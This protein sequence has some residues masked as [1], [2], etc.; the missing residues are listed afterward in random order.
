MVHCVPEIEASVCQSG[1]LFFQQDQFTSGS[2]Q[3]SWLPGSGSLNVGSQVEAGGDVPDPHGVVPVDVPP[4][5]LDPG[6]LQSPEGPR[7]LHHGA[8]LVDDDA[9]GGF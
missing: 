8:A 9:D 5:P 3:I 6:Q 4:R 2:R 7:L 1:I